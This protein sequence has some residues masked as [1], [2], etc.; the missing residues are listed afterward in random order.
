M[1][2][3]ACR[4]PRALL[5][6]DAHPVPLI[7]Q[8]EE[9]VSAAIP[10]LAETGPLSLPLNCLCRKASLSCCPAGPLVGVGPSAGVMV[11][12]RVTRLV[13]LVNAGALDVEYQIQVR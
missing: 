11:A 9:D 3:T 8:A 4:R 13:T 6:V 1:A 5:L 12:D 7:T 10:L 2:T